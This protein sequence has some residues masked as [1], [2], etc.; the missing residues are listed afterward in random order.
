M[1]LSSDIDYVNVIVNGYEN[2]YQ[3]GGRK[4]YTTQN[5]NSSNYN[6]ELDGFDVGVK[7]GNKYSTSFSNRGLTTY[8]RPIYESDLSLYNKG[9]ETNKDLMHI[10][11]I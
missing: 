4:T 2:T 6:A 3:Y 1:A 9:Y 10:C 8:T 5:E 7:F 11:N